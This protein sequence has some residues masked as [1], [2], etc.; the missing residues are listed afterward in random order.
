MLKRT[1]KSR[2]K[3]TV[4]RGAWMALLAATLTVSGCKKTVDDPTLAQNVQTALKNDASIAKQPVQVAVNQGVVTLSGNVTDD[5]ASSVAAQDAARVEG[6]KEVVNSIT[7]A[8]IQVAPTVTSPAAPTTP[9]VA[10]TAE[11]QVIATK[12]TLPPPPDNKP[13]PAPP[14]PTFHEVTVPAGKEIP[15]RITETLDSEHTDT[16]ARFNGVITRNVVSDGMVVLPA[17][18][19]VSGRVVE[20]KDAGRFKGHSLLSIALT[21]VRRR[22][23]L[24][25]VSSEPYTVQGKNRGKNSV[26]KIGG[27]AAVGAV[28][29]GIFG[30][31]KGAA[32]GSL[33]GGGGGAAYQGLTHGEQVSIPS[34]TVIRFRLAQS[35]TV[36]T[37][38][39]ASDDRD[40]EPQ[41][42]L[43]TREPGPGL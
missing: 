4:F 27:G 14:A 19:A 40:D 1:K 43:R 34:E 11:R 8:G 9:R 37:S 42:E 38:E 30:G 21:S 18:S 36:R 31:G 23:A 17:G 7:V 41:P 15:V 33:A 3:T 12:K 28:L 25:S 6:V 22:G 5:T 20:A 13:A 35:F 16:G 29:G 24:I 26:A 2:S 39:N 10:T 32:I